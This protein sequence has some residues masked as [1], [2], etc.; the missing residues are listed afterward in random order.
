MSGINQA[1]IKKQVDDLSS[2]AQSGMKQ[3]GEKLQEVYDKNVTPEMKQQATQIKNDVKQSLNQAQSQA[4]QTINQAST[5]IK[6]DMDRGFAYWFQ[7]QQSTAREY[8]SD[9]MAQ[10]N[11]A[12]GLLG[13]ILFTNFLCPIFFMNRAEGFVTFFTY[14]CVSILSHFLYQMAPKTSPNRF[15]TSTFSHLLWVPLLFWL[16]TRSSKFDLV[17]AKADM[18]HVDVTVSLLL[19]KGFFLTNWIR[20]LLTVNSI[21]LT[22]DAI[23]LG[24][25]LQTKAGAKSIRTQGQMPKSTQSSGDREQLIADSE[26][27]NEDRQR[28]FE[29][30]QGI[31]QRMRSN[32]TAPTA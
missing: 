25:I 29:R 27:S 11:F 12:K 10:P 14:I 7:Q 15:F 16:A 19:R 5:K 2:Q 18:E 26:G 21:V 22:L 3:A 32:V 17:S 13:A 4:Q 28:A 30:E 6:S 1:S 8:W 31:K 23:K 24:Q 9:I 20:L